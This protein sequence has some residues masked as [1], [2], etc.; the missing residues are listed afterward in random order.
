VAFFHSVPGL[1]FLHRLI[2]ALHVVFVEVGACGIR[3]VCLL[4]KITGLDRFVG[5]SY[6][7]QQQ[8]NC[9]VEQAIVAYR[10]EESARLAHEM[11]AKDITLTQDET[12]TGGLSLV[13][14]EPVSNYILLEQAAQARDHDTWHTLMEQALAGLNCR[15]IEST[16]DEAPGLLAYVE[17]HLGAHHSPDLFH[18]QHELSKAVAPPLA[19]KQRATGKAVAQAEETLKRVQEH[20][21]NATNTPEKRG[22]GRPPKAAASLKQ[23]AQDVAAARHE[24]QRLTGQREQVTQ[25]IRAIGHAYHFVDLERGVRRNGKL[26]AGDIQAHID[27]IRTIAQQEHL[28]ETCLDRIA[29]AERVVPKMQAT[30]EFVSGY[31]RQQVRQLDLA[32]PQS[33]AMHAHLIP[34]CYLERVASTRTVTQGEP[35]RALAERLRTPLFEPGGA[36]SHLTLAEQSQLKAEATKLADVFQRSSSNVEGRNGYLS[37][38]NHELRGE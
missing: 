18:V 28:S 24:H 16:S 17:Q 3:L 38:R 30:I 29:K 27:T 5:A 37:L 6:G 32:Q 33:S 21:D 19:V 22:P 9:R 31:V 35:L 10:H 7:T 1:A 4:L 14:I 8:V 36:L 25:H 34:S 12:F 13:G 23:V 2:L 11:P 20:L 26:I 15:V